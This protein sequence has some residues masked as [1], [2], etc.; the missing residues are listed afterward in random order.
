MSG[1]GEGGGGGGGDARRTT[2]ETPLVVG[3]ISCELS[4]AAGEFVFLLGVIYYRVV[5]IF[6]KA[7]HTCNAVAIVVVFPTESAHHVMRLATH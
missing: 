6:R 5:S 4:R 2:N 1:Y 7:R 3:V